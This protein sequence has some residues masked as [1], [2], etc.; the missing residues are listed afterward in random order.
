[1][2]I[3]RG[4]LRTSATHVLTRPP[5]WVRLKHTCAWLAGCE[6]AEPNQ[7][8]RVAQSTPECQ[9][10]CFFQGAMFGFGNSK[11]SPLLFQGFGNS[12]LPRFGQGAFRGQNNMVV[13]GKLLHDFT[14]RSLPHQANDQPGTESI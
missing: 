3:R 6:S 10:I 14:F 2:A 1:M 4:I 9:E 7:P 5:E 8:P 11:P 13:Y 12:R